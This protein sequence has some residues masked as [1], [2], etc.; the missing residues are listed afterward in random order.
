MSIEVHPIS[1]YYYG[2]FK[3]E[4]LVF[5]MMH[6]G[7]LVVATALPKTWKIVPGLL[8]IWGLIAPIQYIWEDPP[9]TFQNGTLNA[10]S[11]FSFY[12]MMQIVFVRTD[13]NL[14]HA[15][16]TSKILWVFFWCD[17]SIVTPL[18]SS[19]SSYSFKL[20]NLPPMPFRSKPSKPLNPTDPFYPTYSF[21][22]KRMI[23]IF[24]LCDFF[25]YI[26]MDVLPSSYTAPAH[27]RYSLHFFLV[28]YI[29]RLPLYFFIGI[30]ILT[31]MEFQYLI[32]SLFF[33]VF[34][35]ECPLN[36]LF[37][38]PFSLKSNTLQRFWGDTWNKVANRAL[39]NAVYTPLVHD[40]GFPK[41]FAMIVTFIAS[42]VF[43][44]Y[45]LMIGSRGNV[46]DTLAMGAY[47]VL[48]GILTI[49]QLRFI[50]PNVKNPYILWC[51]TFVS[52]VLPAG[53]LCEP[54]MG[55]G[56]IEVVVWNKIL[57]KLN[58]HKLI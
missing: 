20:F 34:G 3:S 51:L 23:Y 58:H 45:A 15:S 13:R 36:R 9:H 47:F 25:V 27:S 19:S 55:I 40:K 33:L 14:K 11:L 30:N 39:R 57:P 12:W 4:A 22:F 35:Y 54:F 10:L 26:L 42:A 49:L 28:D 24:L 31:I 50:I 37:E 8:V 18:D 6:F 5:L 44:S 46:K 53:L 43:H 32:V 1:K 21:L 52:V 48:Q 7:K 29:T 38:N 17:P 56:G 2:L 41:D 16:I